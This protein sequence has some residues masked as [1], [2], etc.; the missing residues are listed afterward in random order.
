MDKL[1]DGNIQNSCGFMNRIGHA[2]TTLLDIARD[3]NRITCGLLPAI[4][5]LQTKPGEVLFCILP[6]EKKFDSAKHIQYVL[7]QAFCLEHQIAIINVESESIKRIQELVKAPDCSCILIHRNINHILCLE[8]EL[9][10]ILR[11]ENS[12]FISPPV[13]KLPAK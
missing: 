12:S 4:R 5:L 10:R 2:V 7:L 11:L 3:E 6:Q 13:F 8:L 1:A 9:D